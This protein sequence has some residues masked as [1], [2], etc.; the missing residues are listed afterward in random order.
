MKKDV[1]TFGI[2]FILGIVVFVILGMDF[3]FTVKLKYSEKKLEPIM[4]GFADGEEVASIDL[5][6]DTVYI[7]YGSDT[8]VKET[9]KYHDRSF[10]DNDDFS[11]IRHLYLYTTY[12]GKSIYSIEL[13]KRNFLELISIQNKDSLNPYT[14]NYKIKTKNRYEEILKKDYK[15][16]VSQEKEIIYYVQKKEENDKQEYEIYSIIRINDNDYLEVSIGYVNKNTLSQ[17]SMEDLLLTLYKHIHIK[18]QKSTSGT[19]SSIQNPVSDSKMLICEKTEKNSGHTKQCNTTYKHK[20]SLKNN[21]VSAYVLETVVTCSNASIYAKEKSYYINN[22]D[23]VYSDSKNS[24]TYYI[25]DGYTGV[26]GNEDVFK[27]KTL[28]KAKELAYRLGNCEVKSY[29]N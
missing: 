18:E 14:I 22:K 25:G 16:L 8:N 26:N 1:L 3:R 17:E 6:Y 19:A 20:M 11:W 13:G 9:F 23:V 7:A 29:E 10:E 12:P 4:M 21:I 5:N 2:A 24:L 15:M 27:G 28:T